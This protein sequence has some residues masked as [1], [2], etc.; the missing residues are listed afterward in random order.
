MTILSLL[1]E[2]KKQDLTQHF[3]L[4]IAF[5]MLLEQLD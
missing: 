3:S 4:L 5:R 2:R 1:V